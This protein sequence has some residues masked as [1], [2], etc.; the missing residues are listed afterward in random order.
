MRS[1]PRALGVMGV[2]VALELLG[3]VGCSSP[4]ERSQTC[5]PEASGATLGGG[6]P[7]GCVPSE[8]AEGVADACGIFVAASGSDMNAGDKQAPLKTLAAAIERAGKNGSGRVYACAETFE[9]A[10]E[11]GGSVTIYGGL[12]CASG[13]RWIGETTKTTVTADE[14]EIPLVMRGSEATVRVEDVHVVARGIEPSDAMAKG[15][16][17]IAALAEG[18]V[19]ELSRCTLE[20]GDAAPGADGAAYAT[21][22]LGGAAGNAGNVA[23]SGNQ[24]FGGDEKVN[25]C[26]TPDDPSDDSIGGA[27]GVGLQNSGGPGAPGSPDGATN[28]G[29]GEGASACTP[30]TAGDPGTGGEPGGGGTGLGTITAAGYAGVA[31][32]DG[33][34][35]TTAQGGGGGGGAKGG[36]AANQC[37]AGSAGGASGGSGGSGGCGG[38]GGKGGGAG[39]SSIALVSLNATLRFEKVALKTGRGGNGGAG[40]PGQDGGIPGAGGAG[41]SLPSGAIGLNG[42]CSGGPGGTGGKGGSGGGGL[43]GHA[44]GI[45][46]VGTTPPSEGVTIEVGDAG[47]GGTAAEAQHGGTAGVKADVQDFSPATH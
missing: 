28:G 1:R 30:G 36:T 15:K 18:A 37:T 26:G 45:A 20:A 41:G 25:T 23:C 44:V 43:G 10:V 14:G 5:A 38:L 7:S 33:K 4:C 34:R 11:V 24:I 35:G 12:A 16:S 17:S 13:W 9:E 31:G 32:T 39:G 6:T 46:Y 21:G 22:A 2:V 29:N 47:E 40:G 3:A 42:G 19:V 8:N 27:G